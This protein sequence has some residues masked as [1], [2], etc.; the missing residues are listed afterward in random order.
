MSAEETKTK[1]VTNL[2]EGMYNV[3]FSKDSGSYK[4]GDKAVY[5]SS[6]AETLQKKG[7]VKVEGKIKVYIPKTMKK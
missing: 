7:L 2:E 6:T 1:K 3:E 5:H 4:K